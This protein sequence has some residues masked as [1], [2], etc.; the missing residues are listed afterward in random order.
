MLHLSIESIAAGSYIFVEDKDPQN[1]FYIIQSGKVQCTHRYSKNVRIYNEGNI[2]GVVSC[3]T[4]RSQ[5]ESVITQTPVKLV[6][7]FRSQY[8]ELIKDNPTVAMKIVQMLS[9]D[10][11]SF[12]EAYERKTGGSDGEKDTADQLYNTACYYES[13]EQPNLACFAYYQ[14]LKEHPDGS[15]AD[16][17]KRAYE[18]LKPNSQ[19]VY[20][21]PT[22]ESTRYYPKGTMIFAEGQ[23]GSELFIIANGSVRISRVVNG[24]EQ[25][26]LYFKRGDMVGDMAL[27]EN[28]VRSANAITMSDTSL[29]VLNRKNF[30]QMVT[31]Q[32]Q[33]ILKLTATL[34]NRYWYSYRRLGNICLEDTRERLVDMIAMQIE[35]HRTGYEMVN[36][37][38]SDLG[39]QDLSVLCTLNIADLKNID[40]V[41]NSTQ[42]IQLRNGHV[43]VTDVE[44]LLRL[45]AYYRSK[46]DKQS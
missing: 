9:R 31:T 15:H 21:E 10:L 34:A 44:E 36:T 38:E 23:S 8:E 42:G 1:Y 16:E 32:P 14:Y 17:A 3:M 2:I 5:T 33:Y 24:E 37:Y 35:M 28:E 45:A 29:M 30:D 27:L 4:G 39:I 11:R 46:R 25:A 40:Y 41:L 18:R 22:E 12:N 6:K 19:T 43:F 26:I 13:K 7:V 20:L